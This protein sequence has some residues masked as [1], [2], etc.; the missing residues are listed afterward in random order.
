MPNDQALSTKEFLNPNSMLTPGFAGGMTMMITNTV[1]GQFDLGYPWAPAIGLLISLLFGLLAVTATAM[2]S[3]QRLVY[4]LLNSLI[5]FTVAV[6]SNT[7]GRN[8]SDAASGHA[9]LE[10]IVAPLA[11]T[12]LSAAHAQSPTTPAPVGWCCLNKKVNTAPQEE[13]DRWGGKFFSTQDKAQQACQAAEA[14]KREKAQGFFR[15]WFKK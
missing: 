10:R 3:W 11:A 4:Y 5:I 13:C 6:G 1:A 7:L 2:P 8:A 9:A 15:Q 14:D 12:R